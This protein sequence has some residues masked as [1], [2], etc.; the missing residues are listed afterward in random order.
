MCVR[1]TNT[2]SDWVVLDFLAPPFASRQKVERRLLYF[3]KSFM[4]AGDCFDDS[5]RRK[6]RGWKIASMTRND[7]TPREWESC[8]HETVRI[9]LHRKEEIN[10]WQNIHSKNNNAIKCKLYLT[11]SSIT[12]P[13]AAFGI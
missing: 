6:L 12:L 5:Q 2:R 1:R 7:E 4:I 11:T 9:K 10:E 13:T 3:V 8:F